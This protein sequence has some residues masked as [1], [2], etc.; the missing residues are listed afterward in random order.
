MTFIMYIDEN[1]GMHHVI[2]AVIVAAATIVT[3]FIA[4]RFF[5]SRDAKKNVK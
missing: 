4:T 1:G 2:I 3:S 5:L